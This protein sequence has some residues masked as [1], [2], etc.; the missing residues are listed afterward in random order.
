M[1]KSLF[2]YL[3]KEQALQFKHELKENN[4]FLDR[5]INSTPSNYI[6]LDSDQNIHIKCSNPKELM[7][8]AKKN[9]YNIE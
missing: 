5:Y 4:S 6:K 2:I 7:A 1:N 8:L 9:L 3:D